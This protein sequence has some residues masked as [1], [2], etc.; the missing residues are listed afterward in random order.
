M[1]L[2]NSLLNYLWENPF[3]KIPKIILIVMLLFLMVLPVTAINGVLYGSEPSDGSTVY[4]GDEVTITWDGDYVQEIICYTADCGTG[5]FDVLETIYGASN[6]PTTF[7]LPHIYDPYYWFKFQANPNNASAYVKYPFSEGLNPYVVNADFNVT[8]T[9]AHPYDTIH[10]FDLSTSGAPLN[11]WEWIISPPIGNETHQYSQNIA[12]I[13]SEIGNYTITL[14]V[15][16]ENE[17]YASAVKTNVLQIVNTSTSVNHNIEYHIK[18]PD[19]SVNAGGEIRHHINETHFYFGNADVLGVLD[20]GSVP[21]EGFASSEVLPIDYETY[22]TYSDSFIFDHDMIKIIYLSYKSS[23]GNE[24]PTPEPTLPSNPT[25]TITPAPTD[26][27]TMD[28]YPTAINLGEEA[29]IYIS[30]SNSSKPLA[31]QTILYYENNNLGAGSTWNLIG[32]YRFNTSTSNWDFRINNNEAWNFTPHDGFLHMVKPITTGTYSY[33]SATFGYNSEPLGTATGDLLI[34]SVGGENSALTMLLFAGD[35]LTTNRLSNYN[36]TLSGD[37]TTQNYVVPYEISISLQRG[38]VYT[39]TGS[40]EGY[41]TRTKTFTV[42]ISQT[43]QQ[44]D[45][46]AMMDILLYPEGQEPPVGNCTVT[47][48]V[49]DIETYFPIPNVQIL[50][51]GFL[52]PKFTGTGGESVSFNIPQNTSYTII[53]SKEGYCTITETKNT[54]TQTYMYVALYMKFGNCVGVTPTHTPI[55]TIP[56]PTITP[57]YQQINGSVGICNVTMPNATWLQR[58]RNTVACVGIEDLFSQNLL[59]AVIIILGIGLIAATKAGAIGFAIGAVLGAVISL[60]LGLI[61]L[62]VIIILI[63]CSIAIMAIKIF[64][65]SGG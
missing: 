27:W 35:A 20:F 11:A 2:D 49:T 57:I 14:N 22:E 17:A 3:T 31:V 5:T 39:L 33:Q 53:A 50:M 24:T 30:N 63:I 55:T 43:I 47:I 7:T 37:G 40:K 38:S 51:S 56:T 64:T 41:I 16:N 60:S 9:I 15:I 59:I 10:C 45:Y 48:Q 54:S 34:G 65:S 61:P 12:F 18:N 19:G 8:P 62:F 29:Q 58:A 44:G 26:V 6:S 21:S 46:G 52:S 32:V 25:P 1:N 28:I 36:L 42:P 13:P 23:G 4:T